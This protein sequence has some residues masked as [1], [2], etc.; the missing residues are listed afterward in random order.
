MG[1]SSRK[2]VAAVLTGAAAVAMIA[3]TP[4]KA[5]AALK[6]LAARSAPAVPA[7]DRPGGLRWPLVARGDKGPRVIDIQ[8][9]LNERI[10]AGLK[11][12]GTFGP[13]TERA[14]RRFQ[15]K[16]SLAANGMVGDQTWAHLVITVKLGSSGP[17]VSAVQHSLGNMSGHFNAA[18]KAKVESFQAKYHIAADGIVGPVTWNALVIHEP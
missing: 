8:Y 12:N 17:A 5:P 1:N 10:G 14:V 4:H 9:L 6:A 11:V 3:G 13:Q 7:R 16:H 15:A 18:T 2:G